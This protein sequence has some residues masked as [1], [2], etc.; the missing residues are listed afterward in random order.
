MYQSLVFVAKN[1]PS[2]Q[3]VHC[4]VAQLT[5]KQNIPVKILRNG[6][7]ISLVCETGSITSSPVVL[8]TNTFEFK[9][10]EIVQPYLAEKGDIATISTR[11]CYTINKTV[12]G[13]SKRVTVTPVDFYGRIKPDLRDHFLSYLEKQTG[14]DGLVSG[15]AEIGINPEAMPSDEQRQRKVWFVGVIELTLRARVDNPQVF[16][17]LAGV[18]IGNRRSYGFGSVSCDMLEKVGATEDK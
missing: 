1:V 13:G 9:R 2:E 8:D 18:S 6:R 10:T 3:E 7:V 14:L 4:L 5:D 16:N 11:L 12:P 17:A 15:A